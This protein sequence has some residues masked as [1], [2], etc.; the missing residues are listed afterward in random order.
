MENFT[1]RLGAWSKREPSTPVMWLFEWKKSLCEQVHGYHS[2]GKAV[3]L[4]VPQGSILSPVL[5]LVFVNDLPEALQSFVADIYDDNTTISYS[6]H[7]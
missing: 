4:E 1:L 6:T 3:T 2:T 5:F 7:Y